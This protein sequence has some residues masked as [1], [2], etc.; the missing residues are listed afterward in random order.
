[1]TSDPR[2]RDVLVFYQWFEA[3]NDH[4]PHEF[5]AREHKCLTALQAI[6]ADPATPPEERDAARDILEII[7]AH[8][9]SHIPAAIRVLAS[10]ANDPETPPDLQDDA[11][12]NLAEATRRMPAASDKPQ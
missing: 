3:T 2:W 4:D 6:A 7:A 11:K 5:L 9:R 8:A 10:I 1:M 12:R